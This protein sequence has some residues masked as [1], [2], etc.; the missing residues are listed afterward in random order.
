MRER[1]KPLFLL[2]SGLIIGTAIMLL[3]V[4]F[5]LRIGSP[6]P[7]GLGWDFVWLGLGFNA[8]VLAVWLCFRNRAK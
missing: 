8:F 6:P 2:A 5:Q 3:G 4:R 1:A 7:T